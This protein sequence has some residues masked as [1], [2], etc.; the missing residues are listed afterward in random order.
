MTSVG[1]IQTSDGY[2]AMA[3]W[4]G[5]RQVSGAVGPLDDQPK[6]IHWVAPVGAC[7]FFFLHCKFLSYLILATRKLETS[8]CWSHFNITAIVRCR[9]FVMPSSHS[10]DCEISK[11]QL[12]CRPFATKDATGQVWPSLTWFSKANKDANILLPSSSWSNTD[13]PADEH[14]L[15]SG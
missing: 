12:P 10:S 6:P 9:R 11:P 7:F 3:F 14:S 13:P 4:Y 15:F 2:P 1:I 5:C 8:I